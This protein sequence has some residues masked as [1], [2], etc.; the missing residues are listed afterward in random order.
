[1]LTKRE[2]ELLERF[3]HAWRNN[4]QRN[5][6][7]QSDAPPEIIAYSKQAESLESL[8]ELVLL[9]MEYRWQCNTERFNWIDYQAILPQLGEQQ[10]AAWLLEEY[11][12]HLRYRPQA[13]ESEWLFNYSEC[14]SELISMM[15]EIARQENIERES[16][17]P[18]EP[19]FVAPAFHA[20][21]PLLY[22]DYD[23]RAFL[24]AGGVGKVYRAWQHSLQR[25]VAV[26]ALRKEFQ[27]DQ[28]VVTRF[29]EEAQL[30][31]Q[32]EHPNIVSMYGLGRF[33][34]GGY[35]QVLDY[36]DGIDLESNIAEVARSPLSQRLKLFFSAC[37]AVQ[38][39]HSQ[40]VLHCDL[41]PGNLIVAIKGDTVH[42]NELIVT[43]FGMAIFFD[44]QRG[45]TLPIGGT[46]GYMAPELADSTIG[47]PGPW[48]DVY[49]LGRVLTT[50][51]FHELT[52]KRCSP[53]IE[54][55]SQLCD[56]CLEPNVTNR[57]QSVD[58]LVE[59]LSVYD[60]FS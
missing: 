29:C 45:S 55:L 48:S 16:D 15:P 10:P 49:S 59:R 7:Q 47:D 20:L 33:P 38:Y 3:E 25:F 24:G 22:S 39:A 56:A 8:R 42:Q 12:L 9:D 52:G 35:F 2:C 28:N 43:D 18:A 19:S 4:S 51:L 50:L 30:V 60:L 44:Q 11:R 32:F 46:P 17:E 6:G 37:E 36:I 41:K 13:S 1:M 27:Y 21:T 31:M 53:E 57:L 26:K 14:R 58:E 54:A 40:G 23:L 5:E 34:G